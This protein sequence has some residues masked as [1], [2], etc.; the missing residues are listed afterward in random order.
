MDPLE[1]HRQEYIE[2][3]VVASQRL[4]CRGTSSEM[5]AARRQTFGKWWPHKA[6]TKDGRKFNPT[7][8]RVR[9]N[10]S[11][12]RCIILVYS[13]QRLDLS[14]GRQMITLIWFPVSIA[15]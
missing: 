9:F 12:F 13:W 1:R 8:N 10:T 3:P 11:E 15:T 5:K 6:T 14:I 2:C 7:P 4:D